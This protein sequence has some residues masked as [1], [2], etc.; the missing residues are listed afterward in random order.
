MQKLNLPTK[1]LTEALEVDQGTNS[2][3]LHAG[4]T[5]LITNPNY[6]VEK[7]RWRKKVQ[8]KVVQ[9][10]EGHKSITLTLTSISIVKLIWSSTCVFWKG[11]PIF[12]LRFENRGKFYTQIWN[13][14]DLEAGNK[15]Y[16]KVNYKIFMENFYFLV[17]SFGLLSIGNQQPIRKV[18][19]PVLLNIKVSIWLNFDVYL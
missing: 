16:I 8:T 14:N 3:R 5:T 12:D 13:F 17:G 7:A 10:G 4:R 6:I 15:G 18:T 11:T 1:Q 2:R 19:H 9:F